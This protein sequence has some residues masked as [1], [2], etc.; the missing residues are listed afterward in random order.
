MTWQQLHDSIKQSVSPEC[1]AIVHELV[2]RF[3]AN[4]ASHAAGRDNGFDFRSEHESRLQH[5]VVERLDTEPIPC[6]VESLSRCVPQC[7]REHAIQHREAIGRSEEHTSELQSRLHLVLRL[8]LE[9]K[10]LRKSSNA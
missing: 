1:I 9:K 4:L 2:Q 3:P 8:L 5:R 6:D 10:K 7:Q